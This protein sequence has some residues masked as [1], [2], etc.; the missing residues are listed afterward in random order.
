MKPYS[1]SC[2]QNRAPIL[3]ILQKELEDSGSLLE[4][5]SGTGQHAVYFAPHFPNL[6]WQTSDCAT[7]HAGILQW[8]SSV[9]RPNIHA[10]LNLDVSSGNWPT[11]PFDFVFSANTVHIMSWPMVKNMFENIGKTL[12][13]DGKFCLYGPFNYN[14]Q[15][16]SESNLRF[17]QWLKDR[18]TNSGI[19]DFEALDKLSRNASLHLHKDYEMPANNRLLVWKKRS[20]SRL[21]T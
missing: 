8:L 9:K 1:E 19:R 3:E 12:K 14:G 21:P 16:T 20:E 15:F 2:E 6:L 18:D 4:I 10:P 7:N 13:S 5:G 17:D 11:T